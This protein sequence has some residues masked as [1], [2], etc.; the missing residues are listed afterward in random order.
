MGVFAYRANRTLR[1]SLD[2]R[3][4]GSFYLF[5]VFVATAFVFRVVNML[6]LQAGWPYL[7]AMVVMNL[8]GFFVF[9]ILM[10]GFVSAE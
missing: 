10:W 1:T 4:R 7:V 9:S 5:P 6:W 2:E 3:P 8:S